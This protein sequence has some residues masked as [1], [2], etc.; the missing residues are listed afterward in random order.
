MPDIKFRVTD[1]RTSAYRLSFVERSPSPELDALVARGDPETG[2]LFE[3]RDLAFRRVALIRRN[4]AELICAP[5]RWA[6]HIVTSV[7]A[8]RQSLPQE[9][10]LK[11]LSLGVLLETRDGKYALSQRSQEVASFK[12]HWHLSAAGYVDLEKAARSTTLL[13]SVFAELHEEVNVSA[14]DVMFVEQLGL[15]IHTGA[16]R[17]THEVAFRAGTKL[18]SDELLAAATEARDSYEGKVH[19]FSGDEIIKMFDT[20]LFNPMAAASIRLAFEMS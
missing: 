5:M 9:Q 19:V 6:E 17:A 16:N 15:G 8:L 18:T 2:A 1:T 12:G 13:H 3:P 14:A 11:V 4:G 7:D 10:R 20:E